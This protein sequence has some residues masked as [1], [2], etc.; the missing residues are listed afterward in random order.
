MESSLP[1]NGICVL[2]LTQ[3]LPGS[4]CSQILAQLGA[5]VIKV[6]NPA[7]GDSFRHYEPKADGTGIFF[8][9]F[10]QNKRSVTLDIK[11]PQG[12]DG[13]KR[14]A[15][16]ADIILENF[17]PDSIAKMGLGYDD[18]SIINESIIYCSLTGFGQDGPYKNRP[19]H[20]LNI[21][22]IAGVL[23]LFGTSGGAPIV[24]I[25]QIA[26][27]S[28]A[29][30]ATIGILSALITKGKTGKGCYI[31][32]A[33]LDS[34][35]PF[36]N[37]MMA[38]F[39]ADAKQPQR[40]EAFLSGGSACYNVY[41]TLDGR[42]FSIGC[43]EEKFWKNFCHVINREDF[44]EHL[45]ATSAK[46]KEMILVIRNI[47]KQKTLTEWIEILSSANICFAPLHTLSETLDDEQVQHRKS[48][49]YQ[50]TKDGKEILCRNLP[51]KFSHTENLVM[52]NA[53]KLGEHT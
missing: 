44:V 9:A 49:S 22:S 12:Q 36:A 20:D 42:Y 48:W 14:I 41:E 31:D 2:D 26:G 30:H 27:V 10:N 17:R 16:K 8:H 46:Q 7:G 52:T 33:L 35:N 24:P 19:S 6:E 53:P 32:I 29:L 5:D 23:D 25:L 43:V 34:V 51:I 15:K 39:I 21:L 18:I 38:Q 40:G 11:S 37:M 45:F 13:I 4:L 50:K 47:C 28:G 3:L 1:L